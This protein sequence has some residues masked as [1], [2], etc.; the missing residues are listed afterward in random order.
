MASHFGIFGL[1]IAA[2]VLYQSFEA[3]HTAKARRDGLPLPDPLGLNDLANWVSLGGRQQPPQA[4][5]AA[6]DTQQPY[7][8]PYQPPYPG[9]GAPPPEGYVPPMPMP[10]VHYRRREPVA[11]IL[12]IGM[13]VLFLLAQFDLF[14]GRLFEFAWPVLLIGLGAWLLVRRYL[15]SAPSKETEAKASEPEH[16]HDDSLGGL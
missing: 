9:P 13:G 16:P 2:W 10:P 3:Y 4:A 11:A 6:A 7:A 8:A 12:L 5:G 1:F 14:S 15:E